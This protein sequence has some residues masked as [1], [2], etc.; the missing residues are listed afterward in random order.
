MLL[1]QLRGGG[2]QALPLA[3][4]ANN[5]KSQDRNP[6]QIYILEDCHLPHY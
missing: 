1:I 3:V 5:F 4:L 2:G 6:V